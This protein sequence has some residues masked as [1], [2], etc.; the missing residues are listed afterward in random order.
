[1]FDRKAY[2]Q[3]YNKMRREGYKEDPLMMELHR[4]YMREAN[5]RYRAKKKRIANAG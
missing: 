5:V 1:M 3:K 2:M 4:E